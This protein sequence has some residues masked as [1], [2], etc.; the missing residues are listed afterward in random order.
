MPDK[1]RP[2]TDLRAHRRKEERRLIVI[3]VIFLVVVGG[4][5]IGLVYGWQQAA[6]GGACLLVGAAV[7]SLL[8]LILALVE[9]WAN[10][11]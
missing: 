8:W 6:I 9:R 1:P 5:V 4:I 2:V 3:I 11:E 7:L 10:R